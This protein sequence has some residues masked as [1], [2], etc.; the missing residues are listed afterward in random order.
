MRIQ[1]FNDLARIQVLETDSGFQALDDIKNTFGNFKSEKQM[2]KYVL[3]LI[4]P[5]KA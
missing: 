3:S 5:S 2:K 4:T 1:G